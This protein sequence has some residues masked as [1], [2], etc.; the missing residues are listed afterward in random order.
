MR[1]GRPTKPLNMTT[2]ERD[3][4]QRWARRRKSSQQLTTRSRIVLLC[5]DGLTN[6][7]V[8]RKIGRAHV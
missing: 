5:D 7:E 8:S 4:L 1:Q 3:T 2:E 6:T